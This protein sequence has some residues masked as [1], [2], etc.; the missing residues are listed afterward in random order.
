MLQVSR[1]HY[2]LKVT[3]F[4]KKNTVFAQL[5]TEIPCSVKVTPSL[6]F[7]AITLPNDTYIVTCDSYGYKITAAGIVE[8]T[9]EAV[10]TDMLLLQWSQQKK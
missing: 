4:V 2:T 9:R 1:G 7:Y 3:H 10:K 5:L 8:R 6:V